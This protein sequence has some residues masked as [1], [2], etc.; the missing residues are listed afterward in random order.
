M[1]ARMEAMHDSPDKASTLKVAEPPMMGGSGVSVTCGMDNGR[2]VVSQGCHVIWQSEPFRMKNRIET[3]KNTGILPELYTGRILSIHVSTEI[4]GI[5]SF[6]C[7][8]RTGTVA[9]KC[10]MQ[11]A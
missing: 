1:L 4:T 2:A 7:L 3:N 11:I 9:P 8:G 6:N 5:L 10:E